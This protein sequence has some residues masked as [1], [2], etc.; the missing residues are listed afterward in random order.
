MRELK[1]IQG[2][3]V[4]ISY[5]VGKKDGKELLLNKMEDLFNCLYFFKD[6]RKIVT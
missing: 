2:F 6:S 5:A 4:Y 3:G 1:G